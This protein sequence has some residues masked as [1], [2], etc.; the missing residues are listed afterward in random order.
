MGPTVGQQ[1]LFRP[2]PSHSISPHT[3]AIKAVTTLLQHELRT[4]HPVKT[5]PQVC[6]GLDGTPDPLGTKYPYV[7]HAEANALLNKNAA[8]V[9]GAVSVG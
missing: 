1:F 5:H 9:D 8:S 7:V 4:P 2:H 3:H 6:R